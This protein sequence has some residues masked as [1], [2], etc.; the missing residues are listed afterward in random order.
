[1]ITGIPQGSILGSLLF[2]MYINDLPNC[3]SS[4]FSMIMYADDTTLFCNLNDPNIT[5]ETLNE[6][7]KKIAQ[8]LNANQLS[9]NVGKTKFMVFHSARK[10][11]QYPVLV[12]NNTPIERVT[13]FKYLGLQLIKQRLKLG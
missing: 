1:M 7:L 6:E 11:V 9:L 5:E 13:N 4:V 12:I 2:S 3:C 8:W 10:V